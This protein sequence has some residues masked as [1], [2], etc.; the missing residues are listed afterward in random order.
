MFL[1]PVAI[2][3]GSKG[4][5]IA[6]GAPVVR[7]GKARAFGPVAAGDGTIGWRVVMPARQVINP[8]QR[9][10]GRTVSPHLERPAFRGGRDMQH[11][12]VSGGMGHARGITPDFQY[13]GIPGRADIIMVKDM[14]RASA[15]ARGDSRILS[16]CPHDVTPEGI[17]RTSLRKLCLLPTWRR[18]GHCHTRS[19]R[20]WRGYRPRVWAH[21]REW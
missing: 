13:A 6:T 18:F 16:F 19:G 21:G 12:L 1:D 15:C 3:F 8:Q 14:P 10:I 5:Q 11:H 20:G 2:A 17:F 4:D 9:L 7:H